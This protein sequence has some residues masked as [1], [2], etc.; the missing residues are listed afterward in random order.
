MSSSAPPLVRAADFA[1]ATDTHLPADE[2]MFIVD[3]HIRF[4]HYSCDGFD[5]SGWGCGYRSVQTILS[6]IAPAVPVPSIPTLQRSLGHMMGATSWIGVQEAVV[7]LDVMHG[8]CVQVLPLRTGFEL[9]NHF[10][11][12]VA[13]FASSGGPVMI[14]GGADVYSKTVIGAR[15][16][17]ASDEGALLILDPH[18]IGPSAVAHDVH[19]LRDGGWA[20]WKPLSAVMRADSFYNIALPRPLSSRAAAAA[21]AD[22]AHVSAAVECFGSDAHKDSSSGAGT[23]DGLDCGSWDMEVVD[24]GYTFASCEMRRCRSAS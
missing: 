24:S 5:D 20:N 16:P 8:A 12:L 1:D 2:S 23:A 3:G 7:L 21:A 4:Y 15:S 18:Y 10:D 9:G 11:L 22:K 13:H 6:W 17:T 19:A 14:G